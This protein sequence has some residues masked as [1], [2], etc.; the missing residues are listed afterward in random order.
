MNE[1]V[2]NGYLFLDTNQKVHT[3]IHA[4]RTLYLYSNSFTDYRIIEFVLVQ[5]NYKI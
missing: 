5:F 1:Y 3:Q 2:D 4:V